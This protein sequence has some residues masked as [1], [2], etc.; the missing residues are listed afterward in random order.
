MLASPRAPPRPGRAATHSGLCNAHPS[1]GLPAA[2]AC[3]AKPTPPSHAPCHLSTLP[4]C[5]PGPQV[6]YNA[7]VPTCLALAAAYYS[8]GGADLALG[9]A[10]PE[11]AA[12]SAASAAGLSRL[13]TG[14]HAAF[15]GYYACCC[16]DTWSSELGQLRC[17]CAGAGVTDGTQHWAYKNRLCSSRVGLFWMCRHPGWSCVGA[18]VIAASHGV[19]A[20]HPAQSGCPAHA[21]PYARSL[22]PQ[23][24]RPPL[25][26][27]PEQ[28]RLI[29][30][31][32]PV[33]KGT[34]GGVTLL[35]LAASVAGGLA[36]GLTF[37]LSTLARWGLPAGTARGGEAHLAPASALCAF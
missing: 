31:L 4:C 5:T 32:R 11:A 36:M 15:L 13:L 20:Q 12:A 17:G 26:C 37:W 27:S 9:E 6:F 24:S 8:G 10:A 16:G 1:S 7:L 34:N 30:T 21:S 18:L 2:S 3:R 33:Q 19:Q 22:Q 28:P 35:G 23:R 29:T 25:P 14:L